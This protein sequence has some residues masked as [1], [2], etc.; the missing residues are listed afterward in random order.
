M[1]SPTRHSDDTAARAIHCHQVNKAF[2]EARALRDFELEASGSMVISL[3]GPSG[4]GKT[5]ALRMIAGFEQ[6]DSGTVTIGLDL[7][8]GPDVFVPPEKRRVGMV[9]QDYAL[10]PH[11]TVAQNVGY[12]ANEAG[13]AR[14][15]AL[16]G[17]DGYRKRMPHELSGG[18]QQRVALARALAPEPTAVL[19]DEPFSNLDATLRDRM[20]REVRTILK[21]S[22]TTTIF[23]THDQEDAFAM[24]DVVAVMR[25]GA[26]LQ[27]ASAVE[28]YRNPVSPWV[29]G[30]VG[31]S[32]VFAGT[33]ALG[34]VET[35]L[36][37]FP[38]ASPLR[39]EVLVM[40][41]PEWVHPSPAIDG[42]AVVVEQEFF[43]H[44]QLLVLELGGTRLRSRVG[45]VP[46]LGVGDRV[47]V[48]IDELV[49]F[50]EDA[51]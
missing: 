41:R 4:C 14:A 22:G 46:G 19:L 3:L 50:P 12:G 31:E 18:E 28:L 35:E 44:D 8:A 2:G 39:G 25:S 23:V 21:E 29:A 51:V 10:F 5:T 7:V 27:M 33:A 47:D 13:V 43:G 26:V 32:D 45:H 11:M 36:G 16:V 38:H 30:F 6:P 48:G 17:L 9:F 34:S 37:T 20:R 49:L 42:A 15:L 40:V 1:T 24:S